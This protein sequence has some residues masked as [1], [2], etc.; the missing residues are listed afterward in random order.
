MKLN[1]YLTFLMTLVWSTT[2]AQSSEESDKHVHHKNEIGIANSPVYFINEKVFSYGLHIHYIRNI[3]DSKFGIGIGFE[4]IFDEHKHSTIGLVGVYRPIDRL[5]F[6]MSP[7]LTFEGKNSE[8]NFALHLETS[9]E[10]EIEDFH[11]G[12]VL[13]FAYDPEDIHLS[14]GI[15]IGYGF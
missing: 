4:Q 14:L 15:H 3:A 6:N 2:F 12:P 1:I 8:V 11:I 5:S 10:F 9:Y 7:G 13:E